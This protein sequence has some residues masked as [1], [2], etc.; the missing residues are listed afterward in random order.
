MEVRD[1]WP[2]IFLGLGVL[3]DGAVFRMLE[4]LELSLYREAA[5][6]VT[7]TDAFRENL[8]SRGVPPE[9]VV[10]ITNG[11]DTAY[12]RPEGTR[13][14]DLRERLG[15]NGKFVVLYCG[16]HGISQGLGAVLRTA[17]RMKANP[18]IEFVFVGDGAEKARLVRDS[19]VLDLHNVRF[20]DSVSKEG[21]R[22][23]YSLAS[24]CLVPLRAV[25]MFDGFIP[26][27]MFEIMAMG[28]P[29]L[30][31]LAGEAAG[32]LRHSGAARIVA[33]ES[34]LQMASAIEE[35]SQDPKTLSR[36]GESG[37]AFVR[38]HYSRSDLALR[39]LKVIEEAADTGKAS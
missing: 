2:S 6:V 22:D 1:L 10:T 7:V 35:L 19:R 31:S 37:S 29:I 24:V 5:R 21:V 17:A 14:D 11:A 39:Y 12:W 4:R 32:I 3:K 20:Y 9:K 30:A 8:I 36:M 16:A 26:S 18:A 28:R 23:F 27:K 33:P 34:D 15:L 38:A 25:P 13:S